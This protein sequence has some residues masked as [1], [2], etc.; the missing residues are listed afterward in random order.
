MQLDYITYSSRVRFGPT[1]ITAGN[2]VYEFTD[3]PV[4]F[5]TFN[6]PVLTE[7]AIGL[8]AATTGLAVAGTISIL[9]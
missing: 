7:S 6:L 3:T 1:T 5:N 4:N 9:F 2:P 8:L